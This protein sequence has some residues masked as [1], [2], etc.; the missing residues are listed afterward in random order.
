MV[1]RESAVEFFKELVDGAL[2]HQ[3]LAANELTA[4]YVVQL[5]ASFVE[6]PSAGGEDEH[7]PLALRLGQALEAGG[8]R[9][10]TT[11]K[12]IGDMSLFVSGFFSDSP[13]R[14]VVD[15]D[16][17]VSIG[18][19]AYTALSR[20]ET[21]TFSPVFAELAD[22]FVR[23][24]DVLSEVSERASLSSNADL[25]RLYERWLKTGSRRSGQLL[26]ERGVVPILNAVDLDRFSPIGDRADLDRLADLPAAPAGT[27]RVGLLGTFARWKGHETFLRGVAQLPRELPVRAYVIGDALY[28]TDGSQH[29][30]V[31]LRQAAASLGIADRVGFTGFI[32]R[33]DAALRALDVV[34][35][36][37][38]SPEPF[39]LVI[40]EAMACGRPV[41]VSAAGGAAELVS[42]DVDAL[43]HTP[44][45]ARELAARIAT[46]AADASLRA[47]IGAAGRATAERVFDRTRLAREL[48]PVYQAVLDAQR[49]I[50]GASP[51][52]S[53]LR[54]NS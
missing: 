39:G 11:L 24:V 37:S 12:H 14:K 3:R 28:Q 13:N 35:H 20:Y 38:T 44:G 29:S 2:A 4:F 32:E 17:Y 50:V 53:S 34:V 7:A 8:M 23:F 18:G 54:A 10:R 15:V 5:L 43:T 25:L 33:S 36:A 6:R 31:E 47:S 52:T 30:G 45:D 1:G 49:S 16:Y 21:D 41:I 46:L 9:Q 51:T 22:N 48:I 27:I 26:A 40:A 42:A 19:T